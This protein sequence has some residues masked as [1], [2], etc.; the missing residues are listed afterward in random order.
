MGGAREDAQSKELHE[1][2]VF[3]RVHIHIL[4]VQFDRAGKRGWVAEFLGQTQQKTFIDR[5]SL[6][7]R[8][9]VIPPVFRSD[10]N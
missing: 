8:A 1:L 3:K 9:Y 10:R 2:R 6:S 5:P 7:S 4:P